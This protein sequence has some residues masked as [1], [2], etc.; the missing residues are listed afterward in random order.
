MGKGRGKDKGNGIGK[1]RG[2]PAHGRPDF[3]E[4]GHTGEEV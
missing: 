2:V 1:K 3:G 4:R